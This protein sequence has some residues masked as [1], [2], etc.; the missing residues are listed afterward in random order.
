MKSPR[1]FKN[2]RD[3]D[4]T[5]LRRDRLGTLGADFVGDFRFRVRYHVILER[6]PLALLILY[7]FARQTD[8]QE[9]LQSTDVPESCLEFP[10]RTL[11]FSFD[12]IT[13]CQGSFQPHEITPKLKLRQHLPAQAPQ[14]LQLLRA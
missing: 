6:L 1:L 2:R 4:G 10:K 7:F 12:S 3:E 5:P 8:W 14:R 13:C 11:F 9:S